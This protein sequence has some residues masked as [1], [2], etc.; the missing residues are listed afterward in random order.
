MDLP[1]RNLWKQGGKLNRFAFTAGMCLDLT[2][3]CGTILAGSFSYS[4]KALA[5]GETSL[6]EESFIICKVFH[7]RSFPAG[8]KD[9]VGKK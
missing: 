3:N 5:E 6:D 7:G 4:R 8:Y 2:A 9:I 1:M